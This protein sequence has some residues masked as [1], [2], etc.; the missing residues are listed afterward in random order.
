MYSIF[1]SAQ[2]VPT[3]HILNCILRHQNIVTPTLI[4]SLN[5]YK[6][7]QISCRL[8]KNNKRKKS[9]FTTNITMQ[10]RLDIT[11][12]PIAPRSIPLGQS[13]AI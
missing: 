5:E 2:S 1:P 6:L 10:S 7:V 4:T 12:R 9:R 11:V 8:V 13:T 3:V